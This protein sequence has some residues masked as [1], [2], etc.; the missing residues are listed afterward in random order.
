MNIAMKLLAPTVAALV[1]GACSS[2]DS[3]GESKQPDNAPSART[4][5]AKTGDSCDEAVALMKG[6]AT[7]G[8]KHANDC[9]EM[10]KRL[11]AYAVANN[12]RFRINT[13]AARKDRKK[14]N[15]R[16]PDLANLLRPIAICS[17]THKRIDY[18]MEHLG[19]M[20]AAR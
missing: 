20:P 7:I 9:A 16:L 4:K 10:T 8:S 3:N 15:D 18:I 5:T 13:K 2:S 14:C 17:K 11:E 19:K 6:L 1:V 12:E